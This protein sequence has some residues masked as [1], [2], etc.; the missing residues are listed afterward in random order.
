MAHKR[1]LQPVQ[2]G[3]GVM[4]RDEV[5]APVDRVHIALAAAERPCDLPV[6]CLH[7]HQIQVHI[8]VDDLKPLDALVARTVPHDRKGEPSAPG[9]VEGLG[10][11]GD[12]MRSRDQVQARRPEG[13]QLEEDLGQLVE[14][15]IHPVGVLIPRGYLPVLAEAAAERAAG[16]EHH[17]GP[18]ASAHRRLLAPVQS[19]PGDSDHILLAAHSGLDMS[20]HAAGVRT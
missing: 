14:C 10:D 11:G 7:V 3:M 20:V 5:H 18:V 13:L 12:E 15:D 1:T 6:V 4:R 17:A 16:E 2:I 8:R 9:Q 19:A